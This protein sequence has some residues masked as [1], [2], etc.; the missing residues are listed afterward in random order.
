M[1]TLTTAER[2]ALRVRAK[3]I[4]DEVMNKANTANRVGSL[5][6]DIVEYLGSMDLDELQQYFLSKTDN[7]TA[8]GIITFLKELK[9]K[10]GITIGDFVDGMVNGKGAAF[11]ENGNGQVESLEVRSYM[12]VMEYIINR[13]SA[14]EGN[15]IFTESGVIEDVEQVTEN[16]FILKLR[17]R[18]DYDFHAFAE[19]DVVYGSVNTL[20]ADGSYYDSWF[21]VLETD[22]AA[23]TITV[24][25]YPDDEVPAG[26]NFDPAKSMVIKRRGN[27]I[28]ENRQ[29]C[30]YLSSY[31]GVIMYLEGVT[32]PILE[33][34]NYYMSLGRPKHLDLFNGLPINYNHPYLFAR[35]AI[36][37]DLLRIDYSGNPIYE[38][39]DLGLWNESAEYMKGYSDERKKYIQHQ[40][41]YDSVCWRCI[42]AQAEVGVPPRWNSTDWIAVAGDYRVDLN[43]Y[44]GQHW[45]RG[46]NVNTR[47]VATVFHGSMDISSDITDAQVE[48]ERI[49]DIPAEDI[50]WAIL[51][52]NDGLALNITPDDLPSNWLTSRMVQYKVTVSVRPGVT[53]TAIFGINK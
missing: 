5:F 49:S 38:I 7:D 1:A 13:I 25:V 51:H 23:N 22:T 10:G 40:V 46:M 31:E 29:A 34:S 21:R 48:W 45:F 41:W 47:L 24:V 6:Y 33:E 44:D 19:G 39:E 17:K 36:I 42:V 32:K 15:F 9:A 20:L 14:Q 8:H 4:R 18:W 37:Q 16:T 43:T 52:Q 11:D 27:A 3:V 2:Q 35:G 12:K 50:A 28:D 26:R 30:W 53:R